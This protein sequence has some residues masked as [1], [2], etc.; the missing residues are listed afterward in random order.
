MN[1]IEQN[2]SLI[3]HVAEVIATI[4]EN[5]TSVT[6]LSVNMSEQA[7]LGERAIHADDIDSKLCRRVERYD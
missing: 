7:E 6:D 5:S 3:Q 4:Q 2:S 1:S